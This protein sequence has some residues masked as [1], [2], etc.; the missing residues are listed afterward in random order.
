M[1]YHYSAFIIEQGAPNPQK[2]AL[3]A[4]MLGL[5]SNTVD[6]ARII[7][8]NNELSNFCISA[9]FRPVFRI[10]STEADIL[11]VPGHPNTQRFLRKF[12]NGLRLYLEG[13][14]QHIV[15][16]GPILLTL[17]KNIQVEGY[18][19]WITKRVTAFMGTLGLESYNLDGIN[20]SDRNCHESC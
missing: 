4:S 16:L 17:G 7:Q 9:G 20:I 3:A 15:M 14:D 19:G 2:E 8:D 13:R 11:Q 10:I 5:I 12:G 1:A 6:Y 18:P